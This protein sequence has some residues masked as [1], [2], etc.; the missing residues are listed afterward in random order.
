MTNTA[1]NTSSGLA[2]VVLRLGEILRRLPYRTILLLLALAFVGLTW[3]GYSESPPYSPR[4]SSEWSKGRPVGETS[5]NEAI[6]ADATSHSTYLV[7]V[8]PS[9]QLHYARLDRG[10]EVVVDTFIAVPTF[11]PRN[12]Q[13]VAGLGD[14]LHLAWLDGLE[15]Q[16][17]LKYARLDISGRPQIDPVVMSLPDDPVELARLALSQGGQVEIFWSSTAGIFHATLDEAGQL[18]RPSTLLVPGGAT[19]AIQSDQQGKIHMVWLEAET[20]YNLSVHYAVFDPEQRILSRP[21]QMSSV[22]FRVGQTL[23]GL[24]L[25]LDK[26]YGY[27]FWSIIDRRDGA[28]RMEY[29]TFPLGNPS[30]VAQSPLELRGV[31]FIQNASVLGGQRSRAFVT[32]SGQVAGIGQGSQIA[33]ALFRQ[34]QFDGHQVITASRD[35]SLK[36]VLL[37]DV[38]GELHLVWIDTIGFNRYRVL[39]ASTTGQAIKALNV[40][41]LWD[42]ANTVVSTAMSLTLVIGFAPLMIAWS[43][44][45]AIWVL[46]YYFISH[47]EDLRSLRSWGVFAV[48]VALQIG[49]MM[50]VSPGGSGAFGRFILPALLAAVVLVGV[51]I[52]INAKRGRSILVAFLIFT[53]THGLLRLVIYALGNIN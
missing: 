32:I 17:A 43:L 10:A 4:A 24:T 19:P 8:D 25:A 26:E 27:I 39:Y 48:A 2:G 9:R 15:G 37:T 28:S 40:I 41:T 49:A 53:L 51:Y 50:V 47:E 46:I 6:A 16:T 23:D 14:V 5:L 7:W 38:L 52:Y 45:P 35:A 13:L 18:V 33:L 34:G 3:W 44:L 30:E 29:V 21:I 31:T 1:N 42:V 12:P 20:S 11:Y 36:P 22:F